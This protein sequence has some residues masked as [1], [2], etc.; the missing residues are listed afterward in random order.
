MAVN[1]DYADFERAGEQAVHDNLAAGK[2][3]S[4][5]AS[6]AEEWL[7]KFERAR[8]DASQATQAATASRAVTAAE[9]A[10]EATERQATTAEKATRIAV[11]ALVIAIIS[12][13]VSIVALFRSH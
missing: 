9:R 13:I 6:L 3:N 8:K 1:D 10:A 4:R 2:Y 7:S 11:A 12:G 5:R